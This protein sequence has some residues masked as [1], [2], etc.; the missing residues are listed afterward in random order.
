MR[1]A[2]SKIANLLGDKPNYDEIGSQGTTDICRAPA[3][4]G[5]A[6]ATAS[7]ANSIGSAVGGLFGAAQQGGHIFNTTPSFDSYDDIPSIG[8]RGLEANSY[9]G[10]GGKYG[11]FTPF[12]ATY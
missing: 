6:Q 8:S 1:F 12:N 5:Q 10:T 11:S 3:A 7:M 9:I 2:G 4:Q